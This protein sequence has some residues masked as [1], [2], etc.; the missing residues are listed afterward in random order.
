MRDLVNRSPGRTRR[1]GGRYGANLLGQAAGRGIY[2]GAGFAAFVMVGQGAGPAALGRYGL[3]LAVLAVAVIAADFGTTLTFG[4]RLGA[5]RPEERPGE[6]ARMLTARLILGGLAGLGLLAALPLLPAEIRPALLLAALLMPLAAARFL[7]ALFQV[8]GRPAWSSGPA[9]ANAIVLLGGTALALRLGA[10]EAVLSAIAV[11]AGIAYGAVG[12]ALAG[13]LVPLGPAPA[14]E[15][16]A[17]LRAAAGVGVA[18]ALGTLNGRISLLMLAGA[19]TAAE[20]GR[21]TAGFRVFEL[22]AAAAITLCAPLVPVFGRAAG[23]LVDGR[24]AA[25]TGPLRARVS[26]ALTLSLAVSGAG[27]VAACALAE[28]LVRLLFGPDFAGSVPV[29]RVAAAMSVV[30]IAATV[31]FAGL[32]PLGRTG[33][34]V[35]GGAA[36]CLVN[37]AG[38]ALL[39][40][41]DPVTG[42]ALAALAAECAMLAVVAHAFHRAA[43]PPLAAA[44]LGPALGPGL[45][46]AAVW[47]LGPAAA[48]PVAV[49]AAAVL[50]AA[51]AAA[52]RLRRP[53]PV[54]SLPV[55]EASS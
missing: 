51:A 19:A 26:T 46:A 41:W 20:L 44:D 8:S 29:V 31:L 4:A 18:N 9:L 38:C 25:G 35:R 10:P 27:A 6:V 54:L 53:L 17:L 49:P 34:A 33:F 42:A 13:R 1:G 39:I 7:D 15:G 47:A 23:P 2:L 16:W 3:A 5:C 30:L 37:A 48:V 11:A 32:V 24:P 43:G 45:L 28:P 40:P 52:L 14:R 21:F 50:A 36:A 12:L 22:G 55:P